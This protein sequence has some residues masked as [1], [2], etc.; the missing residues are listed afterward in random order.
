MRWAYAEQQP[1]MFPGLP[2]DVRAPDSEEPPWV[3]VRLKVAGVTGSP[4]EIGVVEPKRMEQVSGQ[5]GAAGFP[6]TAN[7]DGGGVVAG[8]E[9]GRPGTL[10]LARTNW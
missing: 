4:P 1:G 7:C 2:A 9:A 5:L 10:E 6:D 8:L 3:S